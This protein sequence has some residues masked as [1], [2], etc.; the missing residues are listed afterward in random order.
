[1]GYLTTITFYNDAAD[2]LKKHPKEVS[3]LIYNAQLGIQ[4]RNGRNYDP[5]GSHANPVII[6]KTR[7]AYDTTIYLHA[8][9]TVI[10]VSEADSEWAVNSF[11]SEMEYHLKKLKEKQKS[12]KN[13]KA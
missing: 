6:Q 13:A 4:K 8:G 9:N 5:I 11:I 2:D 10:D 12:F 1:M 3:E 7:H